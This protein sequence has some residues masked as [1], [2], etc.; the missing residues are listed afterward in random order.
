MTITMEYTR[1]NAVKDGLLIDV[2]HLAKNFTGKDIQVAI[3]KTIWDGP[4]IQQDLDP[5]RDTIILATTY[6]NEEIGLHRC[7]WAVTD[8][9]VTPLMLCVQI[10]VDFGRNG[11]KQVTVF[12]HSESAD[13]RCPRVPNASFHVM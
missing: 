11:R 6:K 5:W 1:E 9:A 2:T 10:K 12:C 13:Y 8:P 4:V 7:G 3:S